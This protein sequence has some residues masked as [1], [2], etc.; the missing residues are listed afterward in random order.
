MMPFPA[1]EVLPMLAMMLLR[2]GMPVMIILMMGALAQR[3][4]RLQA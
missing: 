1:E 3:F 4:E 2:L